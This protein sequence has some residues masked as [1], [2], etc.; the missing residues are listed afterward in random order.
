MVDLQIKTIW[1]L[2]QSAIMDP[3]FPSRQKA[4]GGPKEW[5]FIME[6]CQKWDSARLNSRA[7]TIFIICKWSTRLGQGNG[8]NVC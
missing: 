6:K 8:Q 3:I 2:R 7:I 4:E 1:Y 5:S